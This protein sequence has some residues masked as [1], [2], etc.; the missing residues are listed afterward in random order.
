MDSLP[1]AFTSATFNSGAFSS[2]KYITKIDADRLYLPITAAV[3]LAYVNGITPGI[4]SASKALV[5]DSSN[6]IVS[7]VN[8]FT[9]T[10]LNATAYQLSGVSM[11]A[12]ALTATTPGTGQA[13]KALILDASAN[14]ASINSLAADTISASTSINIT[15]AAGGDMITLTSTASTARNT[16]KFVTNTQSWECGTRG[17]TASNSDT[18]YIYNGGYRLIMQPSG[19]TQLNGTLALSAG[20]SHLFLVNGANTGLIEVATSPN[21]LRVVNGFAMNLGASGVTIGSGSTQAARYPIDFQLAA[22]DVQIC[23]F[24][25]GTNA[26][27]GIGANNSSLEFHS[28]SAFNWYSGTTA[29]GSLGTNLLNLTSAGTLTAAQNLIASAGVHASTISTAGLAALG[30]SAHMHYASGI[31]SFFT[32]NYATGTYGNTMIGN[33]SIVS[34]SN[35]YV[36]IN[37][38]SVAQNAP[39]AVFGSAGFTR[40]TGFGYL[41][42]SGSGTA[43][44]FTNRPFS[45]YSEWGILVGSGEIDVFSDLRIKKDVLALDDELCTRFIKNIKPIQFKYRH[46]EDREHYG[47]A[48]QQLMAYGFT[49]LV[50]LTHADEPLPE[51]KIPTYIPDTDGELGDM[52]LSGESIDLPG[53]VRCVVSMIDMIPMLHKCIQIQMERLDEQQ[54]EIEKLKELLRSTNL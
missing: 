26:L 2:G 41:A 29:N 46:D 13:S 47:Y 1:P 30:N 14:I 16:I 28:G 9:T 17:S 4:G 5:L 52:K 23:F 25:S 48:A 19:N 15:R 8:S 35:G 42:S 44:G 11:L 50:G 21:I 37:T 10:T 7:G 31:G 38:S 22:A 34:C 12:S 45:I 33:N 3:G 18:F 49:T 43:V 20:G 51:E 54:I 40:I 53:D 24:Q 39:L 6:N 32:Y 36:N 27:Y